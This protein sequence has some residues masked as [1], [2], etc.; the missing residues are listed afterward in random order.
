MAIPL[1]GDVIT[2][3]V[4]ASLGEAG[5]RLSRDESIARI[6]R[7]LKLSEGPDPREF[8]SVYVW[9]LIEWGIGKPERVLDFFRDERIRAAFREAFTSRQWEILDREAEQV[10]LR[11]VESSLQKLDYDPRTQ[12]N[13]FRRTFIEIAVGTYAVSD[14]ITFHKLDD[15]TEQVGEGFAE[16]TKAI[17]ATEARR[18]VVPSPFQTLRL[19]RSYVARPEE[20][21][22]LKSSVLSQ[23]SSAPGVSAT[24]AIQG[25]GGIG[26]TVLAAALTQD[27]EIQLRFKDGILSTTLGQEPDVLAKVVNW[28]G[29]LG[30]QGSSALTIEAASK[31]L[32]AL[33]NDRACLLVID[34]AWETDHVRPFVVGGASCRALVTTRRVVVAE[35]LDADLVSIDVMNRGAKRLSSSSQS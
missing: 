15:L 20:V 22:L 8:E 7:R 19:P 16:V 30:G 9:A 18:K 29:A 17:N 1:V 14:W 10:F 4:E 2:A 11:E 26:K 12:L 13:D 35:D 33:L 23:N 28:I 24:T 32:Q 21:Q 6:L 3:V 25:Q 5:K 27:S 31:H 34:D